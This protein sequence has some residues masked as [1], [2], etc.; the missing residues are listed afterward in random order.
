[1]PQAAPET[2]AQEFDFRPRRGKRRGLWI[3][4]GV[5]VALVA[6]IVA[7]VV[8]LISSDRA[9]IERAKV[10]TIIVPSKNFD[11]SSPL[12][13]VEVNG[14]RARGELNGSVVKFRNESG[15]WKFCMTT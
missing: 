15:D 13:D 11:R 3:G 14:K 2:F 1:M 8:T 6:V 7:L 9:V 12:T 5:A 4:V 10:T